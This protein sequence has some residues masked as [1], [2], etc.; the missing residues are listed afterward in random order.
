MN[1]IVTIPAGYLN[2][3]WDEAEVVGRGAAR[4]AEADSE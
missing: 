2:G 3:D 1:I 4:S